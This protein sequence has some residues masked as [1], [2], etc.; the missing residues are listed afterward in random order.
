M[1]FFKFTNSPSD[2]KMVNGEFINGIKTALWFERYWKLGEFKLTAK[3]SSGLKE[4]LPL[5]TF[6]SHLRSQEIMTVRDHEIDS[7]VDG[8]P[9]III[10]GDS[11]HSFFDYKL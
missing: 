6:I 4:L 1:D 7:E 5:G 9:D 10:T 8:D 3:A 11:F 2:T